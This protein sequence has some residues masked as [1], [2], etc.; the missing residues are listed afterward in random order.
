M[1]HQIVCVFFKTVN[2][3]S[4]FYIKIACF[5][6]TVVDLILNNEKHTL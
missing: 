2:D 3:D 4:I 1:M 6:G 5:P